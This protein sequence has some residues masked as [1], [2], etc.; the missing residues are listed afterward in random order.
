MI[1]IRGLR[2]TSAGTEKRSTTARTLMLLASA[3]MAVGGLS[4]GAGTAEAEGAACL[5]AGGAH[6]Q[7]DTVVAGGSSFSCGTDQFGAPYWH[8]GNAAGQRSTVPNPGAYTNPAGLFSAGARQFGTEYNDYC[9][10]SQ[11]I[12]GSED[13]YQVVADGRGGLFWKAAGPIDQW[14]FDPGSAPQ[15]SWRSASL[16][17]DGSLT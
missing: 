14:A 8:R 7:G 5:W 10:G 11:L 16:C 15:K 6:G 12:E 2:A 4:L 3:A 17:Y 13:V 1:T 9:V